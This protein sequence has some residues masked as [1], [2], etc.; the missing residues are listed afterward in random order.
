MGRDALA[1]TNRLEK[2]GAGVAGFDWSK[3]DASG[4]R[5]VVQDEAWEADGTEA[6]GTRWSCVQDHVTGLTWEVKESAEDHPRYGG[7][8]YAWYL[9]DASQNGGVAGDDDRGN[10]T[11]EPCNTAHYV[12]WVNSQGLCGHSDWRMPTVAELASLAVV[13]KVLPA[14][15]SDFFPNV[16]LPRFFTS[17]SMAGDPSLAWYVYFSDG[18]VSF[19]NKSDPSHVRLVRGGQG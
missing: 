9:D 1:L 13:T 3:V 4:N 15:D 8:S 7:H 2:Q 10:C 11:T 12:E 14:M 18:S 6:A 17:Q 16:P 19:T 5:L